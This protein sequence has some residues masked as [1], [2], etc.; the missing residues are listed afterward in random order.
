LR[1]WDVKE[2]RESLS[3]VWSLDDKLSPNAVQKI[4]N[5]SVRITQKMETKIGVGQSRGA[6]MQAPLTVSHDQKRAALPAMTRRPR[7]A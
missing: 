7:E 1:S 4:A 2:P 6:P 3:A 5:F